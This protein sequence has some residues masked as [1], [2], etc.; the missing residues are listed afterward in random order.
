MGFFSKIKFWDK[1]KPEQSEQ[2]LAI[3]Q[4][5]QSDTEVKLISALRQAEPK[6]SHWLEIVLE[7]VEGKGPLFWQRLQFLFTALDIAQEEA[8]AFTDD[9][10]V[11]LDMM[12]Y[13]H[14]ADF[15]SELQFR[16]ALALGMEDEEDEHSRLMVK[17][18]QGLE[19]TKEK[20]TYHIDNL[21]LSHKQ[22]DEA[23]WHDLEEV[24]IMADVGFDAARMLTDNLRGRAK[25]TESTDPSVFK[26]LLAEEL[27]ELFRPLVRIKALNPPEVVLMVGVNGAGKTTTIAKLAH[28]EK[29]QGK[30]V[31]VAAADTFRAAAV[32][33]LE[34]W[35]KRVGVGFYSKGTGADPAAVAY[36]A[37]DH[38]LSKGYDIVFIDTAGRLQTQVNLMDELT[39]IARVLG[40]KHV[41]APHRTVLV[42]DAT[43]GQNALSQAE[44]FSKAA[45]LGEIILTK[46][47]GTAKGGVVVAVALKHNL[48]IT[49]VGLGEKME[50][51][52][53]FKGKDFAT[54]LL[55]LRQ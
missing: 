27:T 31:L 51:L 18:S 41:G 14:L 7:G 10:S 49:F 17:L 35:A 3:E 29:M 1:A 21:V 36:E 4:E 28:R 48:P 46:L 24:L 26:S 25:R 55:G 23:F 53:P 13:E 43:T 22:M 42:L 8:T 44:L 34:V 15:R 19:K 9:F 12:E 33:Q 39:K 38:A 11:W 52:R 54:A 47:D 45:S 50:D 2:A 32:E 30:K 5:L 37:V 20:I 16:L 40:K 6:L